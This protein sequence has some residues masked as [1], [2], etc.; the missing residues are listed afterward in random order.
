[1][2]WLR[3]SGGC[4]VKLGAGGV[5]VSASDLPWRKLAT[6]SPPAGTRTSTTAK[7][8]SPSPWATARCTAHGRQ[9]RVGKPPR[10]GYHTRQFA[11][12]AFS[13]AL[14]WLAQRVHAPG[15]RAW[16]LCAN[17]SA[18][19]RLNNSAR[20]PECAGR[21]KNLS[22]PLPNFDEIVWLRPTSRMPRGAIKQ[23]NGCRIGE[24]KCI[25]TPNIGGAAPIN[26]GVASYLNWR[27][28]RAAP[29]MHRSRQTRHI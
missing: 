22:I 18:E 10:P 14:P 13:N 23:G 26:H 12:A 4:A 24:S 21:L 6:V 11:A 3:G 25:G 9:P 15:V 8:S 1:V 28:S 29:T 19:I 17:G 20:Q 7:R 2:R 16:G 5:A 27:G